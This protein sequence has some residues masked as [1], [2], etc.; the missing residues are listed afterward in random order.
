M[1]TNKSMIELLETLTELNEKVVEV[2]A[3]DKEL[4]N[5]I[6]AIN[7]KVKDHIKAQKL[8]GGTDYGDK[9]IYNE[10]TKKY[11]RKYDLRR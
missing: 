5:K 3:L 9:Y 11:E 6:N 7:E 2:L 8:Q 10:E 1:A 4:R